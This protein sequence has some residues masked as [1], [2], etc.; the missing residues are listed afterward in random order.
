MTDSH[1]PG[2]LDFSDGGSAHHYSLHPCDKINIESLTSLRRHFFLLLNHHI[3]TSFA[4]DIFGGL[5]RG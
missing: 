2:L 5:L 1:C 4:Q 3:L